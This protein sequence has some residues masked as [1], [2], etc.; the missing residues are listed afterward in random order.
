MR[1]KDKAV[2]VT[3]AA[4]GLGLAIAR[5]FGLEGAIVFLGDLQEEQGR[6]AAAELVSRGARAWFIRL[7][8]ADEESWKAALAELIDR[9]GKLDVLVN[10]AGI[11]IRRP[12]EEMSVENLDRMLA[13]NVRGP[14]LGIKHALPLMR[15]NGGGSIIN[16][17][18]VCSLIG[19]KF[20]PEAYTLVKGALSQLTRS[21]D[22]RYAKD[23][24]RANVLCPSTVETPLVQEMMKDPE[25]RRERVGEVP[26]GRLAAMEDVAAAALYLASD[27]AAF[28]NGVAFPVDGGVTAW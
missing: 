25:R 11:N 8:V 3:G 17:G 16:M 21:V 10:N 24:I 18:S 19:H 4:Q 2:L 13:V 15:R 1:L 5:R 14:F 26:L 9:A 23:N 20:T 12:I 7:D 6:A 28:I 27:E 22:V